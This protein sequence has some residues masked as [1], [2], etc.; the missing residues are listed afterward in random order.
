ML[1][2]ISGIF[3]CLCL[4]LLGRIA[5]LLRRIRRK[6]ASFVWPL[7][8]REQKGV[9]KG[10]QSPRKTLVVLGSGGHT[11]EMIQ[12]ICNLPAEQYDPLI[13]VK[14]ETDQTSMGRVQAAGL[15]SASTKVYN[16]PRA[17]E[18]GQSY[19]S[20]I[21]TTLY[22]IIYAIQLMA[23]VKPDLLICNGPGTCLPLC[24]SAFGWRVLGWTDTSIVFIESYC[25][26]ETMSLTGRLMYAWV[27]FCAVHWP[28]L[29]AKY[30]M[31]QCINTMIRHGKKAL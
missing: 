13:F 9:P 23:S 10:N 18:V 15:V 21:Y 7:P 27:D 16:I 1:L 12:L 3:I 31:T 29:Q 17:R 4:A 6:R 11:S 5:F 14:A 22:A 2:L 20:S 28:N 26:V 24:V 8:P 19:L 30:P 25:R